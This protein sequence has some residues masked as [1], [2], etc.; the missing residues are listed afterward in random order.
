[1]RDAVILGLGIVAGMRR[2]EISQLTIGDYNRLQQQLTIH[3]KHNTIRVVPV[4][5]GL[6][7]AL[8][9][10]LQLRGDKPGRLLAAVQ[11][12]GKILQLGMTAAAI[13][14]MLQRRATEAGVVEFSP[15]DM[16]RTFASNLLDAGVDIVTVQKLMGHSNVSTTAGYDRRGERAKQAG[17][18]RLHM[19]WRRRG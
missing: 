9:E 11:K 17:I 10:W 12:D 4:Q 19:A 1:M 18:G 13:Y 15:H 16:R 7:A 8:D 5:S 14:K 6:Q 2:D 3:G